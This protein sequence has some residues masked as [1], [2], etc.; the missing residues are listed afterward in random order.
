MSQFGDNGLVLPI[1]ST[2][3]A[4]SLQRI[5]ELI[6][7]KIK[8]PC[9]TGTVANK[10]GTDEPDCTVVSHTS[11]GLNASID[12]TVPSCA[13]ERRRGALLAPHHRRRAPPAAGQTVDVSVDIE[14]AGDNRAERD[15]QLRPLHRRAFPIPS[16]AARS[17]RSRRRI[18]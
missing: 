7:E 3:F 13:L 8:P 10:P 18:H 2:D 12:A 14:P 17:R 16:A 11:N 4:P 1:C 15:R 5:G 6:N 9:I